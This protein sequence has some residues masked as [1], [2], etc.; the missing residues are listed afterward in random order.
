MRWRSRSCRCGNDEHRDGIDAGH[1]IRT[2]RCW[3]TLERAELMLCTRCGEREAA[4]AIY[5]EARPA[6]SSAR[7]STREER[8]AR[9]A[10]LSSLCERCLFE[11]TVPPEMRDHM[12]RML[13][14]QQRM[15]AAIAAQPASDDLRP[16][17][18]AVEA[19]TNRDPAN[20]VLLRKRLIELLQYLVS[21]EGR[22]IANFHATYERLDF[23]DEWRRLP[24]LEHEILRA[25]AGPTMQAVWQPELPEARDLLPEHLLARLQADT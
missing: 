12:Q 7:M 9:E 13:D 5:V 15:Y 11:T 10:E 6:G 22:T 20:V 17:L 4:R 23:T 21:P 14:G 18:D 8:K 19:E 24:A 16:L 2:A 3:F 1:P 25:L